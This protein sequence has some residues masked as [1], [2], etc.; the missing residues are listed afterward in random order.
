MHAV[1]SSP[2]LAPTVRP[3]AALVITAAASLA[4]PAQA[5][6]VFSLSNNG[7]S[8]V[9]FDSAAPGTVVNVGQISGDAVHLDG[10]DFR[11][12]DGMLYGYNG[13]DSGI[14]RLNLNTGATTRVSTSTS[15]VTVPLGID[16]NPVADR[17]RVV[18]P[19]QE[20]RRI[21]IATGAATNDGALA[22]GS[23]DANQGKTPHI[24]DAAYT[25][26][27]TNP[28]TGTQLYYIDSVLDILVST[29]N[30][31]GGVLSTVGAL[32]LDAN[33][34]TGF[35]ILTSANGLN[36]GLAS[37]NNGRSTG[38]YSIDLASGAASYIGDIGAS[39][40]YGLAVLP[41]A[42]PEPSALLLVSTAGLALLGLGRRRTHH[43]APH[44]A[45]A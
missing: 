38:L 36:T 32:G 34:Y 18:T 24:I 44:H 45:P 37:F 27:D 26:S 16:F 28:A 40:L 43:H 19:N 10:L 29:T 41:S 30:P 5:S 35:D 39:N 3:L 15:P 8:L 33:D 12:A 25:N 11:P 2:R 9:R 21:N 31:N 42:V 23:T 7:Q 13:S 1:T 4:V 17:L 14:Y 22:Y 20:N 6:V